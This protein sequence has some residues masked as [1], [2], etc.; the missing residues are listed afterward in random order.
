MKR[1]FVKSVFSGTLLAVVLASAS[2]GRGA[3]YTFSLDQPHKVVPL[4]TTSIWFSGTIDVLEENDGSILLAV[5]AYLDGTYANKLDVNQY[6]QSYYDWLGAG[7]SF[8]AGGHYAG[9]LF[10]LVADPSDPIGFYNHSGFSIADNCRA[11]VYESQ[12]N[13]PEHRSN[14]VEYSVT[15]V[16]EPATLAA[17][18][19]GTLALARRRRK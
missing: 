15:I 5:H 4:G 11:Y 3:I 13:T 8:P 2:P 18:S 14:E 19:L 9:P 1:T 17:L 12:Q 16:P 6:A 7:G 10:E